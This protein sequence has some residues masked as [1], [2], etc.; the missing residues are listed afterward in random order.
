MD[1]ERISHDNSLWILYRMLA[2]DFFDIMSRS[3]NSANDSFA[4]NIK[5]KCEENDKWNID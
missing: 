5:K 4:S 2:E 1:N 3:D